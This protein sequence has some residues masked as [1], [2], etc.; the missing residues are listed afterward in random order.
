MNGK[1]ENIAYGIITVASVMVFLGCMALLTGK[2]LLDMNVYNTYALQADSWRQGRLDLGQNYTWLELAVYEGKYYSSFPLFPSYIL[3]PFTFIWGSNT[4]DFLILYVCNMVSAIFA[5]K[6]ALELKVSPMG[7]MIQT[8]FVMIGS[9]LIFVLI[10][11]S[12]WFLAQSMCFMLAILSIYFAQKGKGGISLFFWACSVGCRPMQ[13][14]YIPVLMILLCKRTKL[15]GRGNLLYRFIVEKWHWGIPAIMVA[16]SYMVLNYLRFGNPFEFGHNY[17]PEFVNA[18][19]GQFHVHY[20]KENIKTLF[21]LPE[22]AEDGRLIVNTMGNLNFFIASP[23]FFFAAAAFIYV[24]LKREYKLAGV[25]IGVLMLSGLYMLVVVM[26]KTMGG[27]HFGNRYTN[28]LLPWIYLIVVM[29]IS[30][31]PKMI[32]YEIPLCIWGMCLNAVG[33]VIVYNGLV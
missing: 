7:A 27:W 19:Y 12:V 29:I 33:T 15:N 24:L 21:R 13:A 1:K 32:K 22:F 10:D 2:R 28:D 8:L 26:H 6:L 4:Y 11:P 31:F 20:I 25:C 17:L 18:E 30:R 5:Y 9:N 3:F 23:I 14:L 16:L